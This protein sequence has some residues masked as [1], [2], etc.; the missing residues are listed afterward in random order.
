MNIFDNGFINLEYDP[1]IDVIYV[2]MPTVDR[3]DLPK[4]EQS[5]AII[6]EHVKNFYIRNML[7]DVRDAKVFINEK[8]YASMISNFSRALLDSHLQKMAR[9]VDE[10]S[11]RESIVHDI[12]IDKTLS[13]VARSF[14][15]VVPALEWLKEK[16]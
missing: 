3:T 10:S 4:V 13:L 1:V 7:L 2:I 8:A 14:T 16:R 12:F 15:E 5:L 6:V 9:V 11:L